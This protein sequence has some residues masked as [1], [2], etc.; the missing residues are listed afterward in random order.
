MCAANFTGLNLATCFVADGAPFIYFFFH[1]FVWSVQF[2]PQEVRD[3]VPKN[4]A[5]C[6][7]F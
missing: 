4:R 7:L 2:L 6:L 3:F 1:F 5:S